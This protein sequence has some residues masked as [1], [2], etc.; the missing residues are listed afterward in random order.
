[1][2]SKYRSVK[3]VV[4]GH[5]F[6][7]LKEARRYAELRLLEKTGAIGELQCQVRYPLRVNG[8]LVTTYVADFVY[9]DG[10][11]DEEDSKVVM[12]DVKGFRTPVYRLKK[13]L[14]AALGWD[15]V[16]V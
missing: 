4:D 15:I 9:R 11:A 16:E 5:P 14:M 3:T 7:S 6:D 2:V 12:E 8:I 10:A 13:K 1:M